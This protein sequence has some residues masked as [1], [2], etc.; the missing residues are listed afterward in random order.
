M[1]ELFRDAN[2]DFLGKKWYCIGV[3]LVLIATGVVSLVQKG[4]PRLGIDFRGGTLVYV[5]FAERPEVDNLRAALGQRGLGSSTIQRYGPE[6]NHELIIGLEQQGSEEEA[7][8]TGRLAILEALRAT[9]A[10]PSDKLDVNG[11]GVDTLT[12]RLLAADP[13]GLAAQPGEATTRYRQ[14]AEALA[15]VRDTERGGLFRSFEEVRAVEGVPPAAAN[16]FEQNAFLSPFVVRNVE[17]VG[18]KVGRQLRLQALGAAL[19][20][21]AGM[22]VY[23]AWR[24]RQWVYGGAAVIAVFH[25]VAVTVGF[26]SLVDY[27]ISLNVVAALLTLVG[28]SVNDTIV[29]F[30][31]V[32]ENVRLLRREPFPQ[33]VNRSIN[34]TLS[35]TILTSGLTFISVLALFLFGGEVLRGFAFTLV[36]GFVVGSYSTLFIASPIVVGWMERK[37]P[38]MGPTGGPGRTEKQRVDKQPVEVNETAKAG[39]SATGRKGR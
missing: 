37:Q 24:F 8:D 2:Y 35:R 10:T 39:G 4:G 26:L 19:Y 14:I 9:F 38:G 1:I 11:A 25:D 15:D 32:R 17:V 21:L 18:P 23:I 33:L 6:A 29:V 27:E 36:V 3:S 22:L 31:R 28:F 12:E 16:F 30:D 34:Q 7:L 20:A 5:K 13:I